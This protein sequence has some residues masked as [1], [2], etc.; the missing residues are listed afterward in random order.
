[1][2]LSKEYTPSLIDDESSTSLLSSEDTPQSA[3]HRRS[4]R[5][6]IP[7]LF[8]LGCS[9]ILLITNALAAYLTYLYAFHT[10][11][12][13]AEPPS[14]TPSIFRNLHLP[15][16]PRMIN[17]TVYDP[18]HN[19][20]RQHGSIEADEAWEK[21]SPSVGGAF[22]IKKEDAAHDGIDPDKHA[23]FDVPELGIDG[24]PVLVETMHQMHCLVS[25][26]LLEPMYM[27]NDSL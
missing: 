25:L 1:M 14:G 6:R 22:F 10:Y 13:I 17:T 18:D 19:I 26:Y 8:I 2:A 4:S 5:R 12:S 21:L 23:H 9:V 3:T 27:I 16:R 11:R 20:Y 24:F 15:P 7:W